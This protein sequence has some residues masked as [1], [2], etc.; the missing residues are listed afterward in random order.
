MHLSYA[1]SHHVVFVHELLM[2]KYIIQLA[3][4]IIEIKVNFILHSK[5]KFLT[6]N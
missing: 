1:S 3:Q 6:F 2:H 4:R 5:N